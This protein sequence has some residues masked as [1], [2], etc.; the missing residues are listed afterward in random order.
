MPSVQAASTKSLA[1][2]PAAT[3][4]RPLEAEP[5]SC[6]G[7]VRRGPT[8]RVPRPPPRWAR[9]EHAAEAV[10][11]QHEV[12]AGEAARRDRHGVTAV[13]EAAH[14][15]REEDDVRRRR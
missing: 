9:G 7:A 2:L 12:G 10:A 13:L 6:A 14:D 15:G 3:S 1:W 5:S 8:A 4:K 11:A